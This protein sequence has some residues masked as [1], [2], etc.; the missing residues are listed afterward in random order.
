LI[1][2]RGFFASRGCHVHFWFNFGST[3]EGQYLR[4]V[5]WKR[6]KSMKFWFNLNPNTDLFKNCRNLSQIGISLGFTTGSKA[7]NRVCVRSS[8]DWRLPLSSTSASVSSSSSFSS[9][10]RVCAGSSADEAAS[11]TMLALAFASFVGVEI[12]SICWQNLCQKVV[13]PS[14]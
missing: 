8:G 5:C 13:V 14:G 10:A 4:R 12:F 1:I 7:A 11:A 6:W 3:G 9:L 2:P